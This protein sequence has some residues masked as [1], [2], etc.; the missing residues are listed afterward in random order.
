MSG[1]R[2]GAWLFPDRPATALVGAAQ[3]A[4]AGGLDEFWLGDEGPQREPLTVL[5]AAAGATSRIRLG[6][7]VTNPYLRH[8]AVTASTAMTVQELAGGRTV[9]GIGAGG[10]LSL[11]PVGRRRDRPVARVDEA[12]RLV[13]AVSEARG[14]EGYE[15]PAGTFR[16]PL[17]IYVGARGERLNRLASRVADGVFLGGVPTSALSTV[18]GWA[19]STRPIAVSLYLNAALD[20]DERERGRAG[21][22][23]ALLDAPETSRRAAGVER[24]DVRAAVTAL[25]EGDPLPARALVR[26]DLLDQLSVPP[27]PARAAARLAGL[28]RNH[29]VDSVGLSFLAPDLTRTVDFAAATAAALRKEFR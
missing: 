4:E 25:H 21:L 9:L 5:A 29:P 23:Y 22:V 7:A 8:A 24:A 17:T 20:E 15:P 28:A 2:F 13:R 12:I 14:T 16:Q 18:I 1:P 26:D 6:I 10:Q 3:A 27:D 11:G 19:R